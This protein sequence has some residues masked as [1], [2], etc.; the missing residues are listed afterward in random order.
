MLKKYL[1]LCTGKEGDCLHHLP[2]YPSMTS[3]IFIGIPLDSNSG[4]HA[5]LSRRIC[6]NN[7]YRM[8]RGLVVREITP[9]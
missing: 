3:D 4:C 8:L 9:T 7:E 5:V 2:F 1:L 6:A